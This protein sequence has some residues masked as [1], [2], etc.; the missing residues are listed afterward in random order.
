MNFIKNLINDLPS[1]IA[2]LLLL[3]IFKYY[4]KYFTRVN[5]LPGPFPWVPLLGNVLELFRYKL[6]VAEYLKDVQSKYGDF[7]EIQFGSKRLLIISSSDVAHPIHT[8]SVAHNRKFLYRDLPNIGMNEVGME[9]SGMICNRN[10]DEWRINREF[11]ERTSRSRNF[12][13]MLTDKTYEMATN[14]FKLWDIMIN[15]NQEIDLSKW[16]EKFTGDIAISTTTGLPSYTVLSYFNSLGYNDHNYTPVSEQE[17]SLKLISLVKSI[18]KSGQ[19][20]ILVPPFIRHAPGISYLNSKFL[21]FSKEMEDIFLELIQ[22][23]RKEI[24]SLSENASLPSDL[25]TLLLTVNTSHGIEIPSYKSLNR[26]LNEH[27][28]F[29]VIRDIFFGSFESITTAMCFVLYYL[30]K[31][32][33]VKSKLLSEI[34]TI[35]GNSTP[36]NLLYENLK[37]LPY[38]DALIEESLRLNPIFP[39]FP[40][41]NSEPVEVGG[42]LWENGQSFL[43][44]YHRINVNENVWIDGEIFDPE[45]F[46]RNKDS[47][48]SINARTANIKGAFSTFGGG[49]RVCPGKLWAL[50]EIKVL[51]VAVLM[52]YDV[53]FVN[54]DQGL[55]LFCDS[56]FH[57]REL[58]IR[59]RSRM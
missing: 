20:F 50:I 28:I 34:N 40:R 15:D 4:Y 58:K 21:N 14:M 56:T 23:R 12:L 3:Y 33:S 2:V 9:N 16:L 1:L 8:S 36:S 35:F 59:L 31:Y 49:A 47:E 18:F 17:L 6:N 41:S 13:I 5:P 26:S 46:L 42:Y 7:C 55:D 39:Y 30:C 52:R 22:K 45:R 19:W 37:N 43:L 10:L 24:D 27:E 54:K 32:P 29:G 48:R 57:W 53:E 38:C 51:L 25:L 11:F 44:H